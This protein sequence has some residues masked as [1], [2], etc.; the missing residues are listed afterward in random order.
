LTGASFVALSPHCT[1]ATMPTSRG[2]KVD[3]VVQAAGIADQLAAFGRCNSVFDRKYQGTVIRIPFRTMAQANKSE[4]TDFVVT[5][6]AVLDEFRSFQSDLAESLLFLKNIERVHFYLDNS[7]LGRT[8]ISNVEEVR[9]TRSAIK[10]SI[11]KGEE[12][13]FSLKMQIGHSFGNADDK[14]NSIRQY[15]VQHKFAEID[16]QDLEFKAWTVKEGVFPWIAVAAA[17]DPQHSYA[18]GR[19]FVTLPLPILMENTH[20]NIHGMFALSRDRRSLWSMM[21]TQLGGRPMNEI[22]WNNFLFKKVIPVAWQEMLIELA[23]L[24]RPLYHYFPLALASP[25]TLWDTLTEDILEIAV[26]SPIWYST[27]DV[28]MP[29]E[30]GYVAV[31]SPRKELLD[32]LRVMEMPILDNIPSRLLLIIQRR[33]SYTPLN[34]QFARRWLRNR[35]RNELVASQNPTAVELL[36]FVMSDKAYIDLHNLPLFPCKDGTRRSLF[37]HVNIAVPKFGDAIYVATPEELTL[38]SGTGNNF[39]DIGALPIDIA[40]EIRTDLGTISSVVNLVKF[41]LDSFRLYAHDAPFHDP[42][43]GSMEI[44]DLDF[45]WVQKLWRWL[46]LHDAEKVAAIVDDCYLIPLEGG[47]F[48]KVL[49]PRELIS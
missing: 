8:E 33:H 13:S 31:T 5:P 45:T 38:F 14:V 2:I 23:K 49:F 37:K 28:L 15:H 17:I 11:I 20:V 27:T 18:S 46:D 25:G 44:V 3:F 9:E 39:L 36:R 41:D 29:L 22:L 32:A 43:N 26:D 34:P 6:D 35:V 10:S 4:I 21:D 12:K 47:K 1:L 24:G 42:T 30:S 16:S 40:K 7:M 19:I 48:R